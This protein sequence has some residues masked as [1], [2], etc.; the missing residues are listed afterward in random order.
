[1]SKGQALRCVAAHWPLLPGTCLPGA[2]CLNAAML[3]CICPRPTTRG[4]R[5]P[6]L[7]LSGVCLAWPPS[8][9]PKQKDARLIWERPFIVKEETNMNRIP[10][11]YPA[12]SDFTN[13][14]RIK[15]RKSPN[16]SNLHI[17][18]L[19]SLFLSVKIAAPLPRLAGR[20]LPFDLPSSA[21]R[22]VSFY[23]LLCLCSAGAVNILFLFPLFC[24]AM[25]PCVFALPASLPEQKN[26]GQK[27]I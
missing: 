16:F 25:L 4:L 18:F 11:A 1:L 3:R 27:I 26:S 7:N 12:A 14:A 19:A 21:C 24:A 9:T 17:F 22:Y 13:I 20:V 8:R 23:F 6:C 15:V 2:P 10:R 5:A